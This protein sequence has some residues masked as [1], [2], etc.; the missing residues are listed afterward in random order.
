MQPVDIPTEGP[1][2]SVPGAGPL[3]LRAR[4]RPAS[5][6]CQVPTTPNPIAPAAA[7]AH[8]PI[9]GDPVVGGDGGARLDAP[10]LPP[11]G[12]LPATGGAPAPAV[13]ASAL[14]AG[15][16]AALLRLARRAR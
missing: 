8:D 16:G 14:L 6:P 15:C 13:I 10:A 3:G 9:A 2:S 5:T 4:V 12:T 11:A 7:P 1:P